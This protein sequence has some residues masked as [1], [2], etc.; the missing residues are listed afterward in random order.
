[1][2]NGYSE[3]PGIGLVLGF[4]GAVAV[5]TLSTILSK[6]D[7]MAPVRYCGRN[8]IIIYLAF[9]LPMAA[10]RIALLK[11][12]IIADTG[13][14]SVIV[15]AMGVIFPLVLFWTVRNTPFGFLFKRPAWAHL[16]TTPRPV[17]VAAE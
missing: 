8:S 5:V 7:L 10:T 15:T 6:S 12:G 4:V 14:I 17:M 1:V 2:F 9:F 11:S 13:T 16:R 3:L